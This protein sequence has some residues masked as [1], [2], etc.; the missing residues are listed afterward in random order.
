MFKATLT[1]ENI[2]DLTR[3][4]DIFL[5]AKIF[6]FEELSDSGL[7]IE[8]HLRLFD[9]GARGEVYQNDGAISIYQ[10][11]GKS[12]CLARIWQGAQLTFLDNL[13]YIHLI[14]RD[15]KHL[16]TTIRSMTYRLE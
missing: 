8:K 4:I 9:P 15:G 11:D 1:Q 7:K 14:T 6:T 2:A 13:I 5:R 10:T 16:H 12:P 3:K